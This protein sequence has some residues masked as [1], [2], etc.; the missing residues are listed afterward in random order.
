MSNSR[1]WRR[2]KS[3][4]FFREESGVRK[5]KSTRREV[6]ERGGSRRGRRGEEG[7]GKG[8]GKY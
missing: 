2:R 6:G 1:R 4:E 7:R 8:K 3:K 5:L